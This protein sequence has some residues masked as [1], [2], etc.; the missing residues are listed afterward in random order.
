MWE[1]VT[2]HQGLNVTDL[3]PAGNSLEHNGSDAVR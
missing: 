3:I 1:I 2:K